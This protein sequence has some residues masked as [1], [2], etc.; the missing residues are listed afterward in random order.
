M[1]TDVVGFEP[2]KHEPGGI[3]P[4][5]AELRT[6]IMTVLPHLDKNNSEAWWLLGT[7]HCHLCE[8]AKVLMIRFLA[9]QPIDYSDVDIADFDDTLM[10]QFATTIPVLL[11]STKRLDYPFSIM[12]LQ[13][14]L[15]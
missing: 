12:D 13:Q 5:V 9:V 4:S 6:S 14:L 8:D 3:E 1:N 15:S 11:T 2:S 10:M 7:S